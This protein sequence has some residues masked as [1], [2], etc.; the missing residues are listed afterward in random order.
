[1]PQKKTQSRWWW[2]LLIVEALFF[3][4]VFFWI[5]GDLW[6]DEVL[7]LEVV[8]G[9]DSPWEIFRDYRF[10]NNHFLSNFLEWLWLR[11]LRLNSS[12]EVLVRLPPMLFGMGTVAAA[13]L[14]WRRFLGERA[15]LL[16]AVL[17]ACSP[18]FTAFAWQ[19]RGYSLA[20][21][22]ST[23]AVTAAAFR[24]ERRTLY[25]GMA[26]FVISLLMP[27]VM[28]PAAMLPFAVAFALL[29]EKGRGLLQRS[30][31]REAALAAFPAAAGAFLGVAYYLT[32]W[33]QFR[34]AMR[35]SGGWTS[36]W[37]VG[38]HVVFAFALHLGV[39]CVPLFKPAQKCT[40]KEPPAHEDP[41]KNARVRGGM[42]LGMALLLGCLAA[43]VAVLL[44][45]S[46]VH[47][48]PFPRVFLPLLPAVTFGAALLAKEWAWLNG[49]PIRKYWQL[50]G[51]VAVGA[52]LVRIGSDALTKWDLEKSSTPPQNLLQQYYRG[53][54]GV[55]ALLQE[56]RKLPESQQRHQVVLVSP[57]DLPTT[58]HYWN[59]YGLP[60]GDLGRTGTREIPCLLPANEVPPGI[61]E[62]YRLH[63]YVIL[64][65]ARHEQ[66]AL[67]LAQ[68]AGLPSAQ[69][70]AEGDE[71]DRQRLFRIVSP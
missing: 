34:T 55:S 44:V 59:L 53:N 48:S 31:L 64:V 58:F 8:L 20:M 25:N 6:Y 47:R 42:E 68:T 9:N 54:G 63:G 39:L 15:A 61:L 18:V 66:E 60:N 13:C 46:P 32:L 65:L 41:R 26:L 38:C 50:L 40:G 29:A 45:P 49:L 14:A 28:P 57:Y 71:Y 12:S 70:V 52:L 67:N 3:S 37:M 1:M 56:Y 4:C 16:T 2:Q 7:S 19:F 22:L 27:L 33:E 21:F 11:G 35:E 23:L 69:A 36:A 62:Q 5:L 51:C 17:L 24:R 43:L 10:A 30:G